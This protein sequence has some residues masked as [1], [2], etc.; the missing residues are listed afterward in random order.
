MLGS[1]LKKAS[2]AKLIVGIVAIP[3]ATKPFAVVRACKNL[4]SSTKISLRDSTEL[5]PLATGGFRASQ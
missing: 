3:P 2:A 4:E 5:L 1:F